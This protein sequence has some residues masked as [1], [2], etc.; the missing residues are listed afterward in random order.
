MAVLAHATQMIR[1]KDEVGLGV[2]P[3]PEAGQHRARLLDRRVRRVSASAPFTSRSSS[4]L[5]ID[6]PVDSKVACPDRPFRSFGRGE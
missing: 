4:K 2:E 5:S 6:V 1:E 3:L